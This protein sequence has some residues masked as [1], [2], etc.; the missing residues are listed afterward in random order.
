VSFYVGFCLC[1]FFVR[2]SEVHQLPAHAESRVSALIT[3]MGGRRRLFYHNSLVR[4]LCFFFLESFQFAILCFIFKIS[5][6]PP[7]NTTLFKLPFPQ[8]T[9]TP[10]S[11][12]NWC[13]DSLEQVIFSSQSVTLCCI[14]NC[15]IVCQGGLSMCIKD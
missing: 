9:F 8:D 7:K 6:F 11:W 14:F 10:I 5:T 13:S 4:C 2:V 1:F 15:S 12:K 3:R